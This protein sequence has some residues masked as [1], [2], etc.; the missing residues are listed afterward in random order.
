MAEKKSTGET[1]EGSKNF[2]K[3][4][5]DIKTR[6]FKR[7]TASQ[8]MDVWNHYDSDGNGFIEGKELDNFLYELVTSVNVQD[9]GPEVVSQTALDQAKNLILAAFDENK[10]G[11]IDIAEL[12]Q[13]LPME[14]NFLL[15]FRRDHPLES[16]VEFM[17]LWRDYDTDCSGFIEADELKNFL[18]DLLKQS[19]KEGE[20]SE[21]QLITYADTMLQLF[22]RN[23]DGKLQISEMAKLLPVRENFLCRPI[24]KSANKLNRDDIERVFNLYDRDHNDYIEDE[25]LHGFLKDLME[26]VQEDFDSSDLEECKKALLEACDLNQDG[27]INR[28]EMYMV[29]SSQN[30]DAIDPLELAKDKMPCLLK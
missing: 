21:E 26:L 11:K 10:D 4:F 23:K 8:F 19:K 6:D 5:R 7:I 9:V 1:S 15:L 2:L 29:L 12:A 14:E 24:F 30:Y 17:K 16:S 3:Q 22:D 13:I 27:R 28:K 25:E 18:Y 20:V